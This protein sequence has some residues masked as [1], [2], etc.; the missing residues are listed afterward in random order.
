A[1][2]MLA[3]PPHAAAGIVEIAEDD[4]ARRAGLLAGSYHLAIGYRPAGDL[5][6]DAGARDPLDAIGAL[7]HHATRTHADLGVHQRGKRRAKAGIERLVF[8]EVE[9][10]DLVR[11]VLRAITRADA[12]VENL[13]IEAVIGMNGPVDRADHLAPPL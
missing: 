6:I 3:E 10:A 4:R 11:A 12:A 2:R 7:F 9:A 5:G 13:R 8:E 1:G